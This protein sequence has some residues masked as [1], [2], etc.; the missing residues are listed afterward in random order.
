MELLWVTVGNNKGR[1]VGI[2][3]KRYERCRCVACVVC[4]VAVPWWG[5][6][7]GG[8]RVVWGKGGE[9]RK[10]TGSVFITMVCRNVNT[11]G[12]KSCRVFL[13]ERKQTSEEPSHEQNARKVRSQ[14]R[15]WLFKP[16]R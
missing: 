9:T 5:R 7:V 6:L 2:K 12:G 3:P 11:G 13:P 1:C 4:V 16:E 10:G 15:G 8:V 14:K